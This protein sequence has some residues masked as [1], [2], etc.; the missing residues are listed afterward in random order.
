MLI[1]SKKAEH[2]CFFSISAHLKR[3]DFLP[4][5]YYSCRTKHMHARIRF[6]EAKNQGFPDRQL[7]ADR[8]F[9]ADGSVLKEWKT[10]L[11][12]PPVY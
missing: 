3:S 12:P 6:F 10:N 4:L 1:P 5:L 9:F 8:V 2:L 7:S 11:C